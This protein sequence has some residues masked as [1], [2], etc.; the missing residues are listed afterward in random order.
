LLAEV[1]PYVIK[2]LAVLALIFLVWIVIT[3]PGRG[4]SF[5]I[6]DSSSYD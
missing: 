2:A 3:L 6:L 4:D 5:F 1:G